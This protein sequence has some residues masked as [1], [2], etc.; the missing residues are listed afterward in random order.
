MPNKPINRVVIKVGTSTLTDSSGRIDHGYIRSLTEQIA[1]QVSAGI[2]CVLVTSGAIRAGSERLMLQ[3]RPKTIPEKQA[4][5]AV[6]QGL[7]L[8][9]YTELFA[10]SGVTA[11]QVLLTR[12]DFKDRTRY[13]NARNTLNKLLDLGCVPIINENDTVA[14]EEIKF[15]DNDTLAAMVSAALGADLLVLLS[16]VAGLYDRDPKLPGAKLISEVAEITPEVRAMAGGTS[17]DAGTGGMRTKVQAG[18]IAVNSGADMVIANGR[19][20]SVIEKAVAGEPVGTRFLARKG[21]THKKRWIAFAS[22]VRGT[23]IINEGASK[24]VLEGGKSLLPAG[25]TDVTGHFSAGDLVNVADEF[26]HNVARGF[27][28]YSADEIR[29]IM[30]LKTSE[31][32]T[33][34][35]YKDFDE[36]IHR[37]NLVRGL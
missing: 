34:L 32:E 4:A 36:V 1:G 24:M 31:I 26:G 11:A 33:T 35:G 16:D 13:L 29:R 8:H 37:D 15:G 17:G 9:T 14:V 7:L 18:E 12:D 30:G 22:P 28:N 10:E 6:G 23:I 27:V 2:H 3:T 5:A 21:L 19:E 25:I 20:P